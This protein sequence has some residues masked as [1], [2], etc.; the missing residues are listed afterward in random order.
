[1]I[2]TLQTYNGSLSIVIPGAFIFKIVTIKLIEPK[3]EAIPTKCNAKIAISTPA[4]T[5]F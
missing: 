1:V 5:F 2:K 3:I 4:A